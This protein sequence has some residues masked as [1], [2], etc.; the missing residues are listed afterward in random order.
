MLVTK[1]YVG[2]IFLHV[3]DIPIGHQHHNMPECDDVTNITV[4]VKY[5]WSVKINDKSSFF[6][7]RPLSILFPHF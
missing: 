6:M 2:D 5:R 1:K 7:E 4:T 3:G